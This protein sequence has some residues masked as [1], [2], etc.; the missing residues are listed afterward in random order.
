MSISSAFGTLSDFELDKHF[1]HC[2]ENQDAL[3]S[4][5]SL[6]VEAKGCNYN[7]TS[8]QLQCKWVKAMSIRYPL[9]DHV[10]LS[11]FSL[12]RCQ[13]RPP[14]ISPELMSVTKTSMLATPICLAGKKNWRSKTSN[15]THIECENH[16]V[17]ESR[18]L[19]TACR[20]QPFPPPEHEKEKTWNTPLGLI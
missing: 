12:S 7:Y 20:N 17:Q 18:L 10:H 2:F 14:F 15:S 11:S 5:L 13:N 3:N 16:F 19:L 9:K 1:D 6:S 8:S 4:K